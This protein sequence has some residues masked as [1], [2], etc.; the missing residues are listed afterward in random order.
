MSALSPIADMCGATSN[1]CFG[2]KAD[3]YGARGD[4]CSTPEADISAAIDQIPDK[5]HGDLFPDALTLCI[6][7]KVTSNEPLAVIG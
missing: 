1:V 3:M 4:V 7:R 6:H 5:C 2:P